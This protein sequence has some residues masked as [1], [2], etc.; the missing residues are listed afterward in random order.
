MYFIM[1]ITLD[2]KFYS[3]YTKQKNKRN[4]RLVTHRSE[5]AEHQRQGEDLESSQKKDRSPTKEQQTVRTTESIQQQRSPET[6]EQCKQGGEN[7][8]LLLTQTP[9][10]STATG[11]ER[12]LHVLTGKQTLGKFTN[13]PVLKKLPKNTHQKK[14][15]NP[16]NMVQ[17]H[18]Q[19]V[20]V[21]M[22]LT[23]AYSFEGK[24]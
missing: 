10:C 19:M 15:P 12:E 3:T 20:T 18:L 23:D 8:C 7:K 5:T 11:Q 24:L 13:R 22:K 14:F 9:V 21:T 17:N 2:I 6:V 1:Y 16:E 4:P